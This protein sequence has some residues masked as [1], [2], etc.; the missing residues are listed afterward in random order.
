MPALGLDTLKTK[1]RCGLDVDGGR[2][3]LAGAQV[4]MAFKVPACLTRKIRKEYRK[5]SP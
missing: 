3:G 4:L 2:W 1:R 5:L